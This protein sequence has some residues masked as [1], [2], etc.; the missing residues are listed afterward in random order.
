[1][2]GFRQLFP[3]PVPFAA[4]FGRRFPLIPAEER[5]RK[6]KKGGEFDPA[7]TA[8]SQE[9]VPSREGFFRVMAARRPDPVKHVMLLDKPLDGLAVV[10]FAH[11]PLAAERAEEFGKTADAIE[12]GKELSKVVLDERVRLGDQVTRVRVILAA[13]EREAGFQR[14]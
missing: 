5:P 9:I 12:F 14:R 11:S 7:K 2:L 13:Q 10:I 6:V 1:M 3:E 4:L 8:E